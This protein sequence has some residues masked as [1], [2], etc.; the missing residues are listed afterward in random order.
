VGGLRGATPDDTFFYFSGRS[1]N[2]A[3]FLLQLFAR[4]YGTNNVNN[5]SFFCHQASGVGLA[6]VTGSGTATIS[7]E[8]VDRC[9]LLVLIGGNPASNHPRLMRSMIDL[10]RR[11][12]R[13]VVINPLREVGLVNFRVPS[14]IRSLLFGSKIADEYLQ[15][16][17]G[18]DI[19]LLT[20]LAKVILELG[21]T[22][23]PFIAAHTEGLD[24]FRARVDSTSWREIERDSGIPRQTIARIACLY[25]ASKNTVFAWTMG[26]THHEHGVH[27]VRAIA[28]LA[29]LRGML[30]R[31][32]AGL[33]PLRGHSNVQGM[34]SMG[35]VPELKPPILKAIEDKLG[36]SLPRTPGLDTLACARRAAEGRTRFAMHLGG[37]LFGSCPDSAAAQAALNKIGLTVFLSTTLNTGHIRGRGRESIILP[38]L[39]RDE[40][41]QATTQ[42]SMFNYVRLS[43]GGRPRHAGPRPEVSVIASIAGAVLGDSHPANFPDMERHASIRRFIA[44]TIPGY[45]AIGRIEA[46]VRRRRSHLPRAPLRHTFEPSPFPRGP[47]PA[48]QGRRRRGAPPHDHPLRGSVQYRRLRG[49]GPLPRAGTA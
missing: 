31:P 33:L 36:L 37:N 30:G 47:A 17:I 10:R 5:C 21:A 16:H 39:A 44:D 7:L 12:G 1:S 32:G 15:P 13:V 18:G 45:S 4:L 41:P 38:V 27:N 34:G 2:E 9:D 28:N 24:A 11:G 26:I 3:G 14:D 29:L 20:G 25:A 8:D 46:G 23:E 48:P 43:D 35:A 42:E 40:D 6:S 19:A 22:D 49:R